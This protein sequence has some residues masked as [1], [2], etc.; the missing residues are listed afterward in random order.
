MLLVEVQFLN[1]SDWQSDPIASAFGPGQQ[2]SWILY[3]VSG[4]ILSLYVLC[5]DYNAKKL[6]TGQ[7]IAG[8]ITGR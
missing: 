2:I 3:L 6:Y 7:A 4:E 8:I 5:T 1:N